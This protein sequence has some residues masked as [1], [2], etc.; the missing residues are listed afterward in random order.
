VLGVIEMKIANA[1]G[2]GFAV[3][4]NVVK[5]FLEATGFLPQLPSA[6]LRPGPPQSLP[7][8][9]LRM[10][11]PEGLADTA[12]ERLRVEA[13]GDGEGPWLVLDRV[14]SPWSLDA[15]EQAL[16]AGPRAPGRRRAAGAGAR[17][18]LGFARG[19]GTDGTPLWME[20]ALVD[21]GPEKVVVRYVGPP[22]AMAFNLSVLRESLE[23]IEADPL[24]TEEIRASVRVPLAPVSTRVPGVPEARVPGGFWLAASSRGVCDSLPEP[25]AGIESSPQGDFTV[26]FRWRYWRQAP[27]PAAAAAAACRAFTI[28]GAAFHG[29]SERFGV[30][31][32]I[33]GAFRGLDEGLLGLEIEAPI[34]KQPFLDDLTRRFLADEPARPPGS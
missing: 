1:S 12:T 24:L 5:D 19:A 2:L 7:G 33:E 30:E 6:R 23:T 11:L 29:R 17:R 26:V 22:D 28:R 15:L 20:Y 13:G 34:E 32:G 9:G 27:A 31:Y 14:A 25:D 16:G 18:V 4:V 3:P 10:S 21:L 8:K